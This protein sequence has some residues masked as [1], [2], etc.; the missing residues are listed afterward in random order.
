MKI[1][2]VI[3]CHNEERN[4]ERCLQS[5]QW[6]DEIIVLDSGSEDK[7]VAICQRYTDKVFVT[8]WPGYGVQKNRAV[9]KASGD[10][11]LSLDADEW[12][13]KKLIHEIQQTIKSTMAKGFY[14]HRRSNFCGRYIKHGLDGRDFVL[15]L[16]K[17]S[18][19]HFSNAIVHES[20]QVEG[21]VKRLKHLLWH[22]SI[23]NLE[24]AIQ[25][26]NRYSSLRAQMNVAKG[27]RGGLLSAI[28]HA[29]WY[30]IRGYF[31]KLG[32]LDG[33]MGLIVA[34]NGAQYAYLVYIK[35]MLLARKQS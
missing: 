22:N 5:V 28:L 24:V 2:A 27:K 19:G 23:P 1:S 31:I 26:M 8:D 12:L 4:I 13:D 15:R 3:I 16:Y 30:F 35:T 14:L 33:K 7:T 11:I 6:C 29:F 10:W 17:R 32:F 9:A 25:K 20:L 18:S 21:Q 34:L